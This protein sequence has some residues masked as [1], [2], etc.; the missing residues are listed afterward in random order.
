MPPLLSETWATAY[1]QILIVFFV[2]ALGIHG[3]EFWLNIPDEIRR[4]TYRRMGIKGW[5]MPIALFYLAYVAFAW[6]LQTTVISPPAAP[7]TTQQPQNSPAPQVISRFALSSKIA[8]VTITVLPAIAVAFWGYQLHKYRR[9]NVI[10][11]LE[12]ELL[13]GV[14]R[15]GI[16][17]PEALSDLTLLGAH[18]KPGAE[19]QLA[20]TALERVASAE[21]TSTKYTGLEL[22]HLLRSLKAIL[23]NQERPGEDSDFQ[24]VAGIL[25]T[26]R[27]NISTRRLPKYLDAELTA[28]LVEE[29]GVKAVRARSDRIARVFLA[30][31][32]EHK[33][34]VMF[35]IGLAALETRHFDIATAA[36]NGLEA[37]AEK[38]ERITRDVDG[39]NLLGLLAHFEY[40]GGSARSRAA[41]F[42]S[43]TKSL[44]VPS[45]ED[46][47][48]DAHQHHLLTNNYITADRI[49]D[50]LKK[51]K[52]GD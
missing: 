32:S 9:A 41:M 42:M 31:A 40:L 2:F 11:R 38:G 37:L 52:N 50:L 16:L 7:S 22:E 29:L 8:T 4:V 10:R 19:K 15:K 46:C 27:Q 44:F 43:R 14:R 35:G 25:R 24:A 39:A 23:E 34:D 48:I 6:G 26:V 3:L 51:T 36:L 13:K 17:R 12:K 5:L 30:L 21:Q 18:G 45:L 47:L 20:L 49:A 28:Q 1:L 33:S